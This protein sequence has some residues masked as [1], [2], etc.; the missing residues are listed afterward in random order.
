MDRPVDIHRNS[1]TKFP[2]DMWFCQN[3]GCNM[4][5]YCVDGQIR[6]GH[7]ILVLSRHWKPVTGQIPSN[8]TRF[9]GSQSPPPC[10]AR[11]LARPMTKLERF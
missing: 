8:L 4:K 9:W 11:I 5:E 3:I 1:R 6:N 10:A 2:V 7:K